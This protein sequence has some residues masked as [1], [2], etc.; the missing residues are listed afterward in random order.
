M[1]PLS[2]RPQQLV[3]AE[4]GSARHQVWRITVVADDRGRAVAALD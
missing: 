3:N 1:L 2:Q 4:N